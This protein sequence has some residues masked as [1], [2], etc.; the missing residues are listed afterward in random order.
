MV[1]AWAKKNGRFVN[2]PMT[3]GFACLALALA[4][5]VGVMLWHLV[6]WT[7]RERD[8]FSALMFLVLV[9]GILLWIGLAMEAPR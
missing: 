9:G 2:L 8:P 7:F 3:I 6:V 4:C 5:C 1:L